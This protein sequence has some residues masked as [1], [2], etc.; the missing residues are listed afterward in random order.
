MRTK[1]FLTLVLTILL[2]TPILSAIQISSA[3]ETTFTVTV[4]VVDSVTK[5]PIPNADVS[6]I[7][8]GYDQMV[9][10]GDD[11]QAVFLDVEQG[12]Y[13]LY[14]EENRFHIPN[15]DPFIPSPYTMPLSVASDSA[16]PMSTLT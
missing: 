4:N 12:E 6:L 3:N 13:T 1:L 16:R 9:F 14:Y 2:A 8:L 7:G 5:D 15:G 11:G 10:T